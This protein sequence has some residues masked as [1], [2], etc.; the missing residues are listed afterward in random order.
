MTPELSK[1]GQVM[2]GTQYTKTIVVESQLDPDLRGEVTFRMLTAKESMQAGL[3]QVQ[4]RQGRPP[5]ALDFYTNSMIML[6]SHLELAV[7]KAPM[8]WYREVEEKGKR[9]LIPDPS[10]I[11]DAQLLISI[12][13]EYVAFR[14]TFPSITR[15][16]ASGGGDLQP[17]T[18]G[19]SQN[20]ES[21]TI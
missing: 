15:P 16:Q 14:D 18:V 13:E 2:L 9:T 5:E 21:V 10:S 20:S 6:L 19:G 8:W 1:A 12:W 7:I 4:Y 17:A 11:R 3:N